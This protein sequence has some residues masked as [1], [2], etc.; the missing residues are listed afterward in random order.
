MYGEGVDTAA[1][2]VVVPAELVVTVVEEVELV[3]LGAS[4][5]ELPVE[6]V[7]VL[8]GAIVSDTVLLTQI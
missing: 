2:V 8:T 6:T 7:M 3:T 4:V 1:V 5:A